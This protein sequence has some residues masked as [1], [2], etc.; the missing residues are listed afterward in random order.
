MLELKKETEDFIDNEPN[1]PEN[2][3]IFSEHIRIY[4]HL[5]K[6][7]QQLQAQH[8]PLLDCIRLHERFST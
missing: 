5:L 2:E 4:C 1:I 7:T 8:R 3:R 6:Q